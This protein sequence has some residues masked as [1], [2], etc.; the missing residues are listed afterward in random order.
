MNITRTRRIVALSLTAMLALPA[1]AACGNPAEDVAQGIAEQAAENAMG[2][3]DVNITDDSVTMTDTEGNQMAIGADVSVPENWPDSVPLYDGGTLTMASVQADGTVYAV[4]S[5]DASPTEAVDAYA[6]M[7]P[8]GFTLEQ[9]ANLAGTVMRE[10][11][12]ATLTVS[13]VAAEVE[14]VTNLTVTGVAN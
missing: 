14:G 1:M 4:W 8:S 9:D 10:Y 6:A 2:G 13:V 12:D 11:Q 7:L 5:T 3:G